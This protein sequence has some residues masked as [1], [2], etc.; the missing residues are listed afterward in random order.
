[1]TTPPTIGA[2]SAP[3]IARHAN[4]VATVSALFWMMKICAAILGETA[5]DLF[6]MTLNVGYAVSSVALLG[7][8]AIALFVLCLRT[9]RRGVFI[10]RFTER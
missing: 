2:E 10:R 5:G 1:L 8:F 4:K 7:I 9:S 6:S 3:A